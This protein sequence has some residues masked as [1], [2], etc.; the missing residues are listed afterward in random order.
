MDNL[1]VEIGKAVTEYEEYKEPI[2]YTPNADGTVEGIVNEGECITLM[3]D[4]NGVNIE[5]EYSKDTTKVI[6]NLVNAIISL[7]GNV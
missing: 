5:A 4:T 3:T 2:S 1:Q 6:E 7:G